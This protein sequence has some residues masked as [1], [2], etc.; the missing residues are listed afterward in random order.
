MDRYFEA[1]YEIYGADELDKMGSEGMCTVAFDVVLYGYQL[2]AVD[3]ALSRLE[4]AFPQRR[5]MA[6]VAENGRQA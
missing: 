1:A 4:A 6:F 3:A 2:Q 5:R